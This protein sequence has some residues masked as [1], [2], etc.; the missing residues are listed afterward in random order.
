LEALF[1]WLISLIEDLWPFSEIEPW[2]NGVYIVNG[3]CKKVVGPGYFWPVTPLISWVSLEAVSIV[4]A[5]LG[6]PLMTVTTSDGMTVTF[7]VTVMVKVVD[8]ISAIKD[9]D[10]YEETTQEL[11]TSVTSQAIGLMDSE[12]VTE[13]RRSE[14][15]Q[16]LVGRLNTALSKFGVECSNVWF[17]NLAWEIKTFRLMQDEALTGGSW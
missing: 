16:R 15:A 5:I 6:T 9:I 1:E 17:T 10:D 8:P 13:L 11:V 4:P 2:E 12:S 3:K 14:L 7:S